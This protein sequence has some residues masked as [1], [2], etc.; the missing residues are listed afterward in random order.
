LLHGI[1]PSPDSR[2][3][4]EVDKYKERAELAGRDAASW[5]AEIS[6]RLTG[7]C[8]ALAGR[9]AEATRREE[10]LDGEVK[11]ATEAY[12]ATH[13]SHD[14]SR[15]RLLERDLELVRRE[16]RHLDERLKRAEAERQGAYQMARTSAEAFRDY[17]QAL[18]RTYCSAN[19]KALR[20]DTLPE[21]M[22]P[23]QLDAEAF[24]VSRPSANAVG[25][26]G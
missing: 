9:I 12:K 10:R 6:G 26:A 2:P 16:R 25:A 20:A 1:L 23:G 13:D 8:E 11:T 15:L 4:H 5:W 21:I 14:E 22:L 7:E 18:M 3:V 24:A 19:R 17:Y